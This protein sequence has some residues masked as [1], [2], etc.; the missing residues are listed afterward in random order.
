[1]ATNSNATKT[2]SKWGDVILHV[3]EEQEADCKLLVSSVL[4]SH[5]SPVFAAMFDGR[6]AEGQL[7]ST[8]S[9]RVIQLPDDNPSS[10]ATLC[11]II[12]MQTADISMATCSDL[13]E[14]AVLAEKYDCVSVLLPWGKM[15][16]S[17]LMPEDVSHG[18]EKFLVATYAL[19]LPEEF[20]KISQSMIRDSSEP[21]SVVAILRD[22]DTIP[23]S[24]IDQILK[25]Q[26]D[27]QK[28]A[29]AAFD[30]VVTG[31]EICSTA[32]ENVGK[33]FK[34][35]R[36]DNLWPFGIPSVLHLK[37]KV[38]TNGIETPRGACSSSCVC[39]P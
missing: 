32:F 7:L 29:L 9:P 4:L 1:M 20:T 16:V 27:A 24:V 10:M 35:F 15:W 31:D 13:V 5:A 18:L 19:D 21:L 36:D 26:H 3:G 12:H 28:R 8:A 33:C 37:R 14:L 6:F 11:E 23:I 2:L 38:D 22:H 34:K 25:G 30:Q 17:T 39:M